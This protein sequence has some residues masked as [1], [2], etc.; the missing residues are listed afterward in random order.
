MQPDYRQSQFLDIFWS[1]CR[2]YKN[3]ATSCL[4]PKKKV[5]CLPHSHT[6]PQIHQATQRHMKQDTS[7]DHRHE[8]TRSR[9]MADLNPEYCS[10][11]LTPRDICTMP[12]DRTVLS[13]IQD[14]L[15]LLKLEQKHPTVHIYDLFCRAYGAEFSTS[16]STTRLWEELVGLNHVPNNYRRDGFQCPHYEASAVQMHNCNF[17]L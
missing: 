16:R 4:W 5:S 13:H 2:Q 15:G 1:D 6:L 14:V 10:Y 11:H 8:H 17:P 12:P 7:L 9:H 3:T